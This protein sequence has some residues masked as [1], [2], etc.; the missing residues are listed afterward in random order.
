MLDDLALLQRGPL[1]LLPKFRYTYLRHCSL[2]NL[3][4]GVV[5]TA[6]AGALFLIAV[7]TCFWTYLFSIVY[8]KFQLLKIYITN[9]LISAMIRSLLRF[10]LLDLNFFGDSEALTTRQLLAVAYKDFRVFCKMNQIS[11]SQ[12]LFRESMAS[13]PS[14]IATMTFLDYFQWVYMAKS[15]EIH[16]FQLLGLEQIHWC[17][18]EREGIQ[19]QSDLLMVVQRHENCLEWGPSS[20]QICWCMAPIRSCFA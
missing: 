8:G 9:P 14:I 5:G 17:L 11:T 2:H 15:S 13:S 12:P 10:L 1:L 6:N 4:L 20:K 3:N 19:L 16:F 18:L 7:S